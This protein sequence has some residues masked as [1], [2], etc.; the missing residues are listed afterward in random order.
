ML[1]NTCISACLACEEIPPDRRMRSEPVTAG[2]QGV[3]EPN[4]MGC[5]GRALRLTPRAEADVSPALSPDGQWLAVASGS[6]QVAP[7]LL[8]AALTLQITASQAAA[9]LPCGVFAVC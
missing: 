4:L 8:Q 9:R 6:G 7:Q 2:H 5:A 3:A 1:H